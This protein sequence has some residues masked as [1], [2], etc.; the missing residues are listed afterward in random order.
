[1][2]SGEAPADLQLLPMDNLGPAV[3]RTGLVMVAL[4]EVRSVGSVRLAADPLADPVV[5]FNL[6]SDAVD[7][8]RLLSGV[9]QLV[10]LLDH[11]SLRALGTA[12]IP[13]TDLDGVRAGLGDYVH[14]TGTCAM[15]RVLDASCRVVGYDALRVCDASAM[16]DLPRANTHLSTV[17]LAERLASVL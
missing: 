3:P 12:A 14:A 7:E 11:P 6:L 5:D 17:V 15:G 8:R 13:P 2:S 16:P 1:M 9:D 10:R 4:M